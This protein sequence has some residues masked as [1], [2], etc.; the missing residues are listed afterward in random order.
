MK[1]ISKKEK[2]II[3]IAIIV[4]FVIIGVIVGANVINRNLENT[5]YESANYDSNNR[6]LIPEYIKEGIT[7][8]GVTGTLKDL[9]TSDATAT[10]EDIAEGKTAYVDGKKIVGTRKESVEVSETEEYS[11]YYADID[12]DGTVDGIIFADLARE[13]SG[14]WSNSWGIYKISKATNLKKYEISER[15]YDGPFG[16]KD[17][18]KSTSAGNDRFYVMDL[19]DFGYNT[20]Y[21]SS[22]FDYVDLIT[23]DSVND[24]G[25]GKSKTAKALAE[26]PYEGFWKLI[27]EEVSEG[28]FVPSKSEWAAFAVNLNINLK[29]YS[30]FGLNDKYWAASAST[31]SHA[32]IAD[33]SN[34]YISYDNFKNRNSTRLCTTF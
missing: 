3:L 19:T 12:G 11:G 34:G 13:K 21:D 27:R 4:I 22:F 25:Q 2:I 28:W 9:D 5:K 16:T 26:C 30:E 10:A 20:W 24:F 14:Q 1:K 23:D 33:F 29:N 17:V 31:T 8:G 32:H 6:N 7:L 18:I 15:N